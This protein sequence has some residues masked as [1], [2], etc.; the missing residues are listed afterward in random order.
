MAGNDAP[1]R[2][3]IEAKAA[4][5]GARTKRVATGQ[6]KGKPLAAGPR[7][8]RE[9]AP[10]ATARKGA[11]AS[12]R[13]VERG[14]SLPRQMAVADDAVGGNERSLWLRLLVEGK[15]IRILEAQPVDAAGDRPSELRG[16]A[17]LEVRAGDELLAV[18]PLVDPGLAVG[19]PD[20][21]S[22]GPFLGHRVM[23]L[24]SYELSIRIDLEELAR[25]TEWTERGT[26]PTL[27][28]SVLKAKRHVGI[29]LDRATAPLSAS[30][31]VAARAASSGEIDLGELLGAGRDT[32]QPRASR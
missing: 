16:T 8:P 12:E 17:F 22:G 13:V 19:I 30:R 21:R 28:I 27:E 7:P 31:A 6:L 9:K 29:A 25:L 14:R 20:Y 15:T 11:G 1:R 26:G 32:K 4:A 23:E 5:R 3:V 18:K 24:P 2:K 10:V